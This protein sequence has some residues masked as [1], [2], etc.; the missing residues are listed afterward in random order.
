MRLS[1]PDHPPVKTPARRSWTPLCIFPTPRKSL[2]FLA[3]MALLATLA[4]ACAMMVSGAGAATNPTT[5]TSIGPA[6]FMWPPDRVWSADA[7]NTAPCGSIAGVQN[8][9]TF[10]LRTFVFLFQKLH[11]IFTSR[12]SHLTM[13]RKRQD[14]A[15]RPRRILRPGTLHFVSRWYAHLPVTVALKE[16]LTEANRSKE[17]Y[18][19]HQA[20]RHGDLQGH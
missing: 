11:V 3:A 6:A 7:D 8:R 10:P 13:N 15:R 12:V 1:H 14:C 4:A 9:T 16:I 19:F 18:G 17:Q 5:S 20:H 2:L